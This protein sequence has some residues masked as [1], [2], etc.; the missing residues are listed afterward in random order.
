MNIKINFFLVP[1]ISSYSSIIFV[2]YK[3]GK[4]TP[5]RFSGIV[6]NES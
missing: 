4:Q 6:A 1:E 5:D 2:P 3:N